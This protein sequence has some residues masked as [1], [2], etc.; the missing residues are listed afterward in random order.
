VHGYEG[1]YC[2]GSSII[3][4][5]L[6]VNPSLTIAAVAER[7]AVHLVAAAGDLGLPARP[8]GFAPHVPRETVGE[9]VETPG[10]PRPPRPRRKRAR[11]RPR[12]ISP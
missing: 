2:M 1:L 4:T 11:R 6:G 5:S 3:P 10:R 8:A 12:T 7:C 9:R